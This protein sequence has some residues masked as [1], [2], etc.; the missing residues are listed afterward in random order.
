MAVGDRFVAHDAEDL[1]SLGNG[2][3][4]YV[5]AYSGTRDFRTEDTLERLDTKYVQAIL[6]LDDA[7][8]SP[9]GSLVMCER[10]GDQK[11]Q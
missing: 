4:V 5:S 3:V 7:V 1:H 8:E 10:L 11:K 6:Q 2:K 9:L